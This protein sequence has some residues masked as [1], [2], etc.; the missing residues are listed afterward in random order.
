M[1]PVRLAALIGGAAAFAIMVFVAV[2][3][4][5]PS[6]P[7]A[8]VVVV[9]APP[10]APTIKV[11]VAA[12]DLAVGDRLVVQDL[13]WQPWPQSGLN[14]AFVTYGVA[15]VAPQSQVAQLG[16]S[17]DALK[18]AM[19]GSDQAA[20][21]AYVG[22]VVREPM[23]KSEPV[24]ASKVVR[25][26]DAGLLAITLQPGMRAMAIPISAESSAGGFILPGDHVDLVQSRQI[27]QPGAPGGKVYV[28]GQVMKNVKV[29]AIDQ[30]THALKSSSAVI[31]ATATLAVTPAQSELL[32]IA[33]AQGPM[34]LIL[35]SYA[36]SDGPAVAGQVQPQVLRSPVVRV[37]RNGASSDVVVAR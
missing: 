32:A 21:A 22:A 3:A 13:T 10:P 33:K 1:S 28:S 26:G 19:L 2:H 25:A 24:L 18:S 30:N 6:R 9:A 35:R 27:D 17:A 5:A 29:L 7:R 34:T 14:P 16:K 12:R 31:G 11:L 8:A 23:L 4:L 20:M 36:D 37:F 15:S